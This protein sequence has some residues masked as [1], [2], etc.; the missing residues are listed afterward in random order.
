VPDVP[1]PLPSADNIPKLLFEANWLACQH[2]HPWDITVQCQKHVY[3]VR[4]FMDQS[5]YAKDAVSVTTFISQQFGEFK[6]E[7]VLDSMP[8]TSEGLYKGYYQNK[9]REAVSRSWDQARKNGKRAHRLFECYLN[10]MNADA[11]R[12]IRVFQQFLDWKR[13]FEEECGMR[14]FRTEMRIRS[15]VEEKITGAIDS[16]WVYADHPPPEKYNSTLYLIMVD[17]KVK[18]KKG[19][20]VYTDPVTNKPKTGFKGTPCE[21]IEDSSFAKDSMQQVGYAHM[22]ETWYKNFPYRGH[23]YQ[24]V[25]IVEMILLRLHDELPGAEPKTVDRA[26]WM[27]VIVQLFEYRRQQLLCKRL[28]LEGEKKEP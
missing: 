1:G 22:L 10:G 5:D 20:E 23:V 24:H 15:S 9:N 18:R 14:I 16:L 12:H 19:T 3:S 4:W 13:Y 28:L 17:Y 8:Q 7:Q 25:R 21:N 26:R 6:K 11:Y 2:A 27:P